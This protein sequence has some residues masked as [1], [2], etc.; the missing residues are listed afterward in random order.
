MEGID[1][2]D[3]HRFFEVQFEQLN[4]FIDDIAER[5]RIL[6]HYTPASLSTFLKLTHL[7]EASRNNNDSIGFINELLL[8]HE[9]I[10]LN[11][12]KNINRFANEF[13]DLGTSDF[14]T[15]LMQEHEKMAW[16]LRAHNK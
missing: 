2:Y 6:R 15:S 1:F 5:I 3:K 12:R 13:N 11:L 9:S 14:I 7:A 10:I 4:E 16:F 8:D